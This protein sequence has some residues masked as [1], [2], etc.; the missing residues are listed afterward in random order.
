MKTRKTYIC[1]LTILSFI[2]WNRIA[3]AQDP[4]KS[5]SFP[6][7][8]QG[9]TPNAIV[10]AAEHPE[11]A[12]L[13]PE[14]AG[15]L[16][17]GIIVGNESKWMSQTK[18]C[19]VM[20]KGKKLVYAVSDPLIA[21]GELVFSV[22]PLQ[23]SDGIVLEVSGNKLP[24]NAQ[25]FWSYGGGYAKVLDKTETRTLNPAYCR[26]NVFSVEQSAFT[27]YFGVTVDLKVVMV[28]TP[29]N[30]AIR[31]SDA[32]KQSSPLAFFESGKKTMNPALAAKLR[33]FNGKKEYFCVY[34]QNA[35]ADYNHFM[36]P[37]LFS[38]LNEEPIA[39]KK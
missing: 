35:Q 34:R 17:F 26:D 37:A 9:I 10:E 30:S 23:T 24:D 14:M 20:R 11:F 15:N 3:F 12:F 4:G 36:I 32:N 29:I 33:L 2:T 39:H 22:I 8:L 21:D 7:S 16:N 27:M 1:L 31:L 38:Q 19:K 5:Y 18:H 13:L 25:L 28:V 6:Y